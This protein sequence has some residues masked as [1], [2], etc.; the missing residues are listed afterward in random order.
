M[1]NTPVRNTV[2]AAMFL[3]L[4]FVLPFFTG[5]IQQIGSM[6]LPMHIPII[7]C[8]LFCSKE[9]GFLSETKNARSLLKL[10]TEE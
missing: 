7:L 10:I 4:S 1:K 8:S 3:A 5:Q 9:Y 2:L 6:L